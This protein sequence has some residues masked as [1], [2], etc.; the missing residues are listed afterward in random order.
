MANNFNASRL[1]RP[2]QL[3]QNS[4]ISN[5]QS[6]EEDLTR[7]SLILLF[8]FALALR[9][10]YI[11]QSTDNPLFG[12]PWIDAFAY[13]EWAGRMADGAWLWNKL[14]NYL[15]VYPAFLAI[16]KI[17]FGHNPYTNKLIQSIMGALM[18]VLMA[19]V[20]G[21]VWNRHVGLITGYLLATNW[22]LIVYDSEM[23][24]ESFSI[25]FQAVALW[26]L[27]SWPQKRR[28]VT[29]AGFAFALSAGTR[30]NLFLIFPFI[31]FWL[32]WL[33]WS[34]RSRAIQ[35]AMLFTIG[36]IL[37][38]GPIMYRN[39][40][41]SGVPMLR[42]QATWSLY[43]GLSPEF[44]ALH[45]PVGAK[46]R[47]YMNK[48]IAEG[49]R[50]ELEYERYWGQKLKVLFKEDPSGVLKTLFHRLIIFLNARE[51]SQ[52]FDVHAY[53]SYS[54]IM[55]LP[56][57]GFWLIGP[58]GL[59]G[60]A[61]VRRPS[62]IQWLVLILTIIS[63]I[64]ILPFKGSDRYRL[65]AVA[66]LSLFAA[67]A[68]WQLYRWMK[69]GQY[70]AFAAGMVGLAA[71]CIISWADWLNLKARSTARHDYF[72][73]LFHE[74]YNRFDEAIVAY[75]KSMDKFDWDPDSPF[76][77]GHV[78]QNRQQ[79]GSAMNYF[80]EAL[81][82]EPQFPDALNGL[83]RNYLYSGNIADALRIA[84]RSQKLNPTKARTLILMADIHRARS[85]IDAEL[86]FLQE[87]LNSAGNLNAGMR[88]ASRLNELGKHQEALGLYRIL[89]E[90]SHPHRII[91]LQ[92]AMLAGLTAS[93][94]LGDADSAE[95]FWQIVSDSYKEYT[96]FS[97]QAEF[98]L[99]RKS[100]EQFAESMRHKPEWEAAA[101]YMIGLRAV[102]T[103]DKEAAKEWFERS[104]AIEYPI[105]SD[106]PYNL[107]VWAAEDLKRISATN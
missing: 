82:R 64:S 4:T 80:E 55:S 69:D 25:F 84:E 50:T 68:I 3:M 41:I 26:L 52:E 43:A 23:F 14:E 30:A 57:T 54:S 106:A 56:W 2:K 95:P 35:S 53:R 58:L 18:S 42:A 70:R 90:D 61:F 75:K 22:M 101:A 37:I 49:M 104:M 102:L 32:L 24:A 62:I 85:D 19:R 99:G 8:V 60:L 92:A 44:E 51:W 38:I 10:I 100:E 89:S 87:A 34:N 73:G 96:F 77:I 97:Q 71:L 105:D 27:I 21:R 33:G 16:Q 6:Q 94:F 93:R 1:L 17:V 46:F 11:V 12:V 67:F 63:I 86:Y 31:I 48:P 15:P 88:L 36:T 29:A 66:M 72:I 20:A 76:R 79:H 47:K 9:I 103:G 78:L 83:A 13:D 107:Q 28:A 45:P 7:S 98:M 5:Q 40:Q 91:R 65:P 39:Y 59:L 74:S 81:A